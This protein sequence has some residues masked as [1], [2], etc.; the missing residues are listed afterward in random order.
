MKMDKIAPMEPILSDK[1]LEG[2]DWIHQIKWDGIR[3]ISY[4][5]NQSIKILTKRGF[6]RTPFYPELFEA[7]DLLKGK[8]AILDGEMVVF[9]TQGRPSF[10]NILVRE[11]VRSLQNLN[12]YV[13]QFPVKY[14]VFDILHLDG[15]DLRSLPLGTR[16]EILQEHLRKSPAITLTDDFKDG[17]ALY[18][19]MKEQNYEGIVSKNVKS[20][21]LEGK[22]HQEWLKVKL[23]KKLLTVVGGLQ[24]KY[25]HPS[26]I[27]V[28][29]YRNEQLEYIGNV[30]SGLKAKDYELF[31]TYLGDIQS[32][33]S[34]FANR[35]TGDKEVVWLKPTLTCWI[36]FMEWTSTGSLRHPRIIGF[37]PSAAEEAQGKEFSYD[38]LD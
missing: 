27:M 31:K 9:D 32:P 19:L 22:K 35:I 28:G 4:I 1:I 25:N 38:E 16:K 29:V 24:L 37:S 18:Q 6:D 20:P 11:R 26:S 5:Q 2:S 23:T 30:S 7:I 14:L 17:R 15:R 12:H 13:N 3:G 36:Q 21:Y 10:S 8:E 34:P 33:K